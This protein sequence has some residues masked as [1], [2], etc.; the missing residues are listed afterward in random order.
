MFERI[1][2]AKSTISE[3]WKA[4]ERQLKR[5]GKLARRKTGQSTT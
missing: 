5:Y 1:L 2:C 4:R 3:D